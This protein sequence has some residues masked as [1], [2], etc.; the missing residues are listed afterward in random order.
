MVPAPSE[1]IS[2][3]DAIAHVKLGMTTRFRNVLLAA[4]LSTTVGI[5]SGAPALAEKIDP[6]NPGPKPITIKPPVWVAPVQECTDTV[7][8]GWDGEPIVVHECRWVCP[9]GSV[10]AVV[11]Y[12]RVILCVDL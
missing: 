2:H 10:P 7:L 12:G 9:I 8:I 11:I 4:L 3:C 1:R 6:I 5:A